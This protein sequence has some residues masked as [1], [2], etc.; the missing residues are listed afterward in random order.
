MTVAGEQHIEVGLRVDVDT[1]QGTREGI[2]FLLDQFCQR[3]ILSSVFF[4]VGPDNMGRHIWRL[5]KPAFLLKMLRSNAPGLYGWSIL[6]QGTFWPGRKIARH[7]AKEMIDTQRAGHEVG[8][9]A[10]DHHFW[11]LRAD[12]L[13]PERIAVDLERGLQELNRILPVSVEC[14][15]TAGWKC[16][17]N[18]LQQKQTRNFRYNSDCRG[19]TLFIPVVDGEA[20]SSPQ[21]PVTLPTYDEIIGSHGITDDNYNQ[22]LLSLIKPDRLN[23]LTIHAEVEGISRRHLFVEFLNL[24]ADHKINFVPLGNLLPDDPFDLPRHTIESKRLPGREGVVCTQ[25]SPWPVDA[26]S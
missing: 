14:S 8:L 3:G 6:L 4:S 11:Q 10:W 25:G 17:G 5:L 23:V 19:N 9:H 18:V 20:L 22:H 26:T 13:S 15:A 2:P 21:I 16:T 24:A 12:R 7:A 1:L